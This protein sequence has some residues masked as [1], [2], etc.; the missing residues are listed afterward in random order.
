MGNFI[1]TQLIKKELKENG[2]MPDKALKK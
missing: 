2:V 1:F